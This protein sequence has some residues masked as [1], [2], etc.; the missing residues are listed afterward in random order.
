MGE[1]WSTHVLHRFPLFNAKVFT[2]NSFTEARWVLVRT[3][4]L[5]LP[6]HVPPESEAEF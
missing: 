6:I 3:R 5:T 2:D 1:S 4:V